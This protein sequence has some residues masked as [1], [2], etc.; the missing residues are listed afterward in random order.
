MPYL[1]WPIYY[2]LGLFLCALIAEVVQGTTVSRFDPGWLMFV[3]KFVFPRATF[4]SAIGLLSWEIYRL[5]AS[6]I[7]KDRVDE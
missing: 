2:L 5:A 1:C 6:R 4:C 7:R 3:C